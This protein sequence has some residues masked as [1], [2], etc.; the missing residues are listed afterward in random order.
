MSTRLKIFT[1]IA[2]LVTMVAFTV[3]VDKYSVVFLKG[4]SIWANNVL[5]T[6]LPFLI[7]G[8]IV[9]KLDG[10][11]HLFKN[12]KLTK[13]LFN[14]PKGYD[15]VFFLSLICGY[16]VGAKLIAQEYNNGLPTKSCLKLATFCSTASP[17]FLLGTVKNMLN[18]NTATYVLYIS[19]V[20]ACILCG[21][22][23]KNFYI[24]DVQCLEK[25]KDSNVFS[26][27]LDA[28]QSI[29]IVG[30]LIAICYTLCAIICDLLPKWFNTDGIVVTSYLLGLIEM[31]TGCLNLTAVCPTFTATV[32]CCSIVSFGG[33][34]VIM[35]MMT[36]L[37]CCKIKTSAILGTKALHCAL[38]T[39]I[40]FLLGKIFIT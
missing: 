10:M 38:S 13:A 21:F 7:M 2:I 36:F 18:N 8:G 19:H 17:I 31:T 9:T 32:L 37:N 34:C 6:I 28:T 23:Y 40:C 27:I 39:I 3:N 30:A 14:A 22:L 20:V 11:H 15:W 35:Q 4:I 16:P 25:Q 1:T 26:A 29:L 24:E 12:S 33:L 5:P